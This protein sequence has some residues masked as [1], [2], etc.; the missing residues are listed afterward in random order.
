MYDYLPD[1]TAHEN[2]NISALAI[3]ND[4]QKKRCF[5]WQK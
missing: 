2:G 1:H 5:V 4:T 3:K